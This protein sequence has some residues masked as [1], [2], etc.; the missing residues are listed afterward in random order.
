MH[1]INRIAAF[2][3]DMTAWWRDLHQVPGGYLWIG[4]G[5]AEAGR[6]LHNPRYDFNDDIR[7]IGAS[8]WGRLVEAEL[9]RKD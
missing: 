5:P 8:H 3:D 1:I 7:S 2:H 9:P 6:L 4:S